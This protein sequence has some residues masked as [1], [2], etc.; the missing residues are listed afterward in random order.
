MLLKENKL[1]ENNIQA[2]SASGIDFV[3]K[4]PVVPKAATALCLVYS[5]NL[6]GYLMISSADLSQ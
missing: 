2:L 5:C 4:N 6:D 3:K 1:P